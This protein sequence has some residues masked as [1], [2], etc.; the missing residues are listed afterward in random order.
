MKLRRL[1]LAGFKS[2][3]DRTEF[4]FDDG[5]TCVVGP[6]G[7]GKSNVVDAI[8]WVLGEQSAKSLRGSEMMDV[9]FNGCASRRAAGLAEVTLEFDNA[10]G[11][12]Q[13]DVPAADEKKPHVVSVTRRLYRSG[14]SEYLINKKVVRLRDVREMFMDTGIGGRSYSLIEQGKV[15][16]MLQA[17]PLERRVIFEE[18]AGISKYKARKREALSK[19]DRVEQ[20]LLRLNDIVSEVQ[21]R[22]RSIKYQAGKARNYQTYSERL[23]EQQGL[24]SLAQYHMLRGERSGLQSQLDQH[25]DSATAIAARIVQLEANSVNAAAEITDLQ[26]QRTETEGRIASISGRIS[27]CQER[28]ELLTG[29]CRE[30]TE[31]LE[32]AGRREAELTGR[33]E[34]ADVRATGQEEELGTVELRIRQCSEQLEAILEQ[35]QT[36]LVELTRLGGALEDEKAAAL[37]LLHQSSRLHNEITAAGVRQEGLVARKGR[38]ETR[39]QETASQVESLATDRAELAERASRVASKVAETTEK[40]EAAKAEGL[41]AADQERQLDVEI[42]GAK[43]Q[44]SSLDSRSNTLIEMRRRGEGLAKGVR[45]VVKARAAGDLGF[46]R[47]MLAEFVRADFANAAVVEAALADVEQ[48]MVVDRLVDLNAGRDELDRVLDGAG[49]RVLCVDRIRPIAEAVDLSALP[50]RVQKLT[51]LVHVDAELGESLEHLLGRTLV[52]DDLSA[53]VVV[54]AKVPEGYRV[55]TR[56]GAVVE[57]DGHVRLG[58]ANSAGLIA[59]DSELTELAAKLESLNERINQLTSRREVAADRRAHLDDVQQELRAAVYEAN[60]ERADCESKINRTDEQLHQLLLTQPVMAREIATVETERAD[61]A[62][63]EQQARRQAGELEASSTERQ[64]RIDSLTEAQAGLGERQEHLAGQLTDHR[65][66]HAQA[67]EQRT[68]ITETVAAIRRSIEQMRREQAEA[69]TQ[70]ETGRERIATARESITSSKAMIEELFAEKVDMDQAATDLDESQVGLAERAE[71][72]R[73]ALIEQRKASEASGEQVNRCR[74]EIGE[75]DVRIESLITRVADEMGVELVGEYDQYEHDD[76]RDWDAVNEEIHLLR[77]KIQRLGNVNLDAISEQDE[78]EGREE[79]LSG[80]MSDVAQSKHQLVELIEKINKMCTEMF[81]E[82]FEGVRSHFHTIFRKLFGG[83]KADIVL[84]DPD[85]VLESG[86]EIIARPPGKELRSL[87]LLSG[88]EK[89]MTT[90]ALVFSIFRTKPSPFCVLDEVDAALDEANNERF[91]LLV[92]EF[93]DQSQFIIITHA[94]RTMAI[95]NLLYG[96]TMQEAGVSK[97]VSVKFEQ[98]AKMVDEN[99]PAAEELVADAAAGD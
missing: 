96:V 64:D 40:L 52:V 94:K 44:R 81:L 30:L 54:A 2:F 73:Q 20:N 87:S 11:T 93:L 90:V 7:C 95:G 63:A 65:V 13:S 37:E 6:N 26:R 28:I 19:L 62:A 14:E 72:I 18:V 80:Q 68:R 58:Q 38:L 21:K 32:G 71:Q 36:A 66:R 99:E 82:T 70:S 69:R 5:I 86:V 35:Q 25:S 45:R 33:M 39:Q 16:E 97:R 1:S 48:Y 31:Q 23:K 47:G 89:T 22:L 55:V 67:V 92:E 24:Y 41:V 9:I 8:K 76:Q 34:S 46:I 91:N 15:A 61:V 79:F 75:T 57:A 59:R 42:G 29:R 56:D 53:A 78:L 17:N 60:T 10:G 43:E 77:G 51:D 27:T 83:G 50:L 49:V 74:V 12:L 88:G 3:G 98:A 84:T 4:V 85:D